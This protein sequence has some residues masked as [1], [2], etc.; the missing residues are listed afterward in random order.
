MK[1]FICK[2]KQQQQQGKNL[3]PNVVVVSVEKIH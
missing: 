1:L 3:H 2:E